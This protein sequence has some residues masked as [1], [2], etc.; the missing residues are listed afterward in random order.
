MR[1]RLRPLLN[2]LLKAG[3]FHEWITDLSHAVSTP[4]RNVGCRLHADVNHD[5][6]ATSGRYPLCA[7][8]RRQET[9]LHTG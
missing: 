8:T 3:R 5:A 1:Q 4:H 2:L 7:R 9:V 6:A